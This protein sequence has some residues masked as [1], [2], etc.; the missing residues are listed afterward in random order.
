MRMP[1]LHTVLLTFACLQLGSLRVSAA[2]PTRLNVGERLA[3]MRSIEP[4]VHR[5][6]RYMVKEGKRSAID[7]WTRTVTFESQD[8]RALM[9]IVQRWD[10]AVLPPVSVV[11]DSWFESGTFRPLTHVRKVDRNGKLEV[12]GYR[13]LPD[14]IVG[15]PELPDNASAD[16]SIDSPEPAF[17]FEYDMELLQA[18]PLKGGYAV[19]IPFYDPGREPPARYVFAV[20]GADRIAMPDGHWVECWV[21]TADYNTGKVISRFWLDKRTQ[22]MIREEQQQPDGAVLVKTLLN[23]ES[24]DTKI[25]G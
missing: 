25:P 13:F 22:M 11:Q 14:R 15:I 3:H 10:K 17:N 18:L 24:A 20:S 21:V 9:H 2:E 12:G 8:G 5:Y 6:L 1:L 19:S 23:P 16:F 7:I 4:G